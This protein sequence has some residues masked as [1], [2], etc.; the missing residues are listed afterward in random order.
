MAIDYAD[1][2]ALHPAIAHRCYRDPISYWNWASL[3]RVSTAIGEHTLAIEAAERSANALL[4]S[5]NRTDQNIIVFV[6]SV[7][8]LAYLSAG[9]VE[10]ASECLE[11]LS[12]LSPT[13][14]ILA[15]SAWAFHGGFHADYIQTL[16]AL[17]DLDTAERLAVEQVRMRPEDEHV[18]WAMGL[19]YLAQNRPQEAIPCF[20]KC[21]R[22]DLANPSIELDWGRALIAAGMPA[23]ALVHLSEAVQLR[24]LRHP[25]AFD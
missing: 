20:E 7:R 18:L 14:Q 17:G 21:S 10:A 5:P 23:D 19:V 6:E 3:A 12:R 9:N 13:E 16:I 4:N 1:A 25:E 15:I 22:M 24:R 11:P 2:S 8:G